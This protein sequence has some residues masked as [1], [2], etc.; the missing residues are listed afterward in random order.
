[1]MRETSALTSNLL[2]L[3]QNR[4]LSQPLTR[5]EPIRGLRCDVQVQLAEQS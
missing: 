3:T 4:S 5:E 1:M 2:M